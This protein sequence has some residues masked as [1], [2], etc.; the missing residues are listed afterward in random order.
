MALYCFT[1]NP[2]VDSGIAAI[3]ALCNKKQLEDIG[4]DDLNYVKTYLEELYFKEGWGKCLF[5]I[6]P[7]NPITNPSNKTE[8]IKKEKWTSFLNTLL[9]D[10]ENNEVE[11][12]Y[13]MACGRKNVV[14]KFSK[15]QIPLTGSGSMRNFFSYAADGENYCNLC[16][17]AIQASP[18]AYYVCGKFMVVHSSNFD[19]VKDWAVIC[20]KGINKQIALGQNLGCYNDGYT[21]PVNAVFHI[22]ERLIDEYGEE[23]SDGT[24]IC[25]YHFTNYNQGPDL[26]IYNIPGN[27]FTFLKHIN[28]LPNRSDWYKIVRKGY[29]FQNIKKVDP[30]DYETYKNLRNQ[31]Y[32]N[33]LNKRS[34]LRYFFDSPRKIIGDYNMLSVYLR[35]V[36]GMDKERIE[37]LKKIADNIAEHIKETD[38]LKRLMRLENADTRYKFANELLKITKDKLKKKEKEPL[39]TSD[40]YVNYVVIDGNFREAQEI[41]L[42]RIYEKLFEWLKDKDIEDINDI[43]ESE[44]E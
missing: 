13:C 19:V 18:L 37:G 2:F 32:L 11:G 35:E 15:T 26:E 6:F 14:K 40:E 38:N 12:N 10:V 42:F 44:V 4:F 21:N 30:D 1:G 25:I 43:N 5:S 28:Y 41:I 20:N 29:N 22:A 8:K 23:I 17:F 16:T 31:V 36:L 3:L 24:E 39:L 7:N 33:L 34:I 27:I 9:S